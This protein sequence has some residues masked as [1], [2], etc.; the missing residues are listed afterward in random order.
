MDH[1]LR[2]LTDQKALIS[3]EIEELQERLREKKSALRSVEDAIT[4]LGGA[5]DVTV[6]T[7][8]LKELIQ[9]AVLSQDEGLTPREL[10]ELLTRNGR[11]TTQQSVSSTL[12]R[13]KHEGVVD[14]T[15]HGKWI[16]KQKETS[17]PFG[18]DVHSLGPGDGSRGHQRSA[19]PEGSI[20]SGS[21]QRYH[22]VVDDSDDIPF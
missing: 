21:T 12:S 15:N 13:L 14:S 7:K 9:E 3:R 19:S 17:S 5:Q 16:A 20:P 22:P 4:T 2:I 8:S 11:S 1:A 6:S 18:D 10:A